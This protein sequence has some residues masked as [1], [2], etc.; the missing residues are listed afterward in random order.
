LTENCTTEVWMFTEAMG[1]G[2]PIDWRLFASGYLPEFLYDLKLL[3]SSRPIEDL[4]RAGHI[5][6]RVRSAL[7]QGLTGVAFSNAIREGIPK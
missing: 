6:P 4:R 2:A 5:M 7:D 3:D 1:L